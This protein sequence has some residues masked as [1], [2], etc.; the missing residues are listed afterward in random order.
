M[1]LV[2][3]AL[4]LYM[5]SDALKVGA[6]PLATQS[7]WFRICSKLVLTYLSIGPQQLVTK[8][9]ESVAVAVAE[10][11]V[12]ASVLSKIADRER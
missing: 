12:A 6:M 1:P 5:S 2:N 9:I 3:S 7:Q 8:S 4:K 10:A 11:E